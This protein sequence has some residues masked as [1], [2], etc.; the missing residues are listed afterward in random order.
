MLVEV[1]KIRHRGRKL[2]WRD[3]ENSAPL[4]GDLDL[5]STRYRAGSVASLTL[6]DRNIKI[7]A[8][9]LGVLYEPQLTGLGNGRMVFRGIESVDGTAYVQEWWVDVIGR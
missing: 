7:E 1:R 2:P 6:Q 9:R 4:V 3:V 5:S 8:G